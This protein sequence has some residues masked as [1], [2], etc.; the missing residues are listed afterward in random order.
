MVTESPESFLSTTVLV[1]DLQPV[2]NNGLSNLQ[3]VFICSTLMVKNLQGNNLL[4]LPIVMIVLP[5]LQ[6][7]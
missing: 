1:Y 6:G 7:G 4:S 2:F 3:D 5:F